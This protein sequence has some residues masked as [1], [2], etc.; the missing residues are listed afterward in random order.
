MAASA[1]KSNRA[2]RVVGQTEM[3]RQLAECLRGDHAAHAF[4]FSGPRGVGKAAV[5]LEFASLLLCDS[6]GMVPC[7]ECPQCTASTRL[8]HPDL[9]VIFPLPTKK[10]GSNEDSEKEFDKVISQ[11]LGVL[12]ADLYASAWPPKA[13]EIRIDSVRSVLHKASMKPYQA[14]SKVSVILHA[15]AMNVAAQNALLK[16][17]EEPPPEAF[18][19]L[20]AENEG[21]LLATIRSRCQRVRLL[22]LSRRDIAD[23]LIEDGIPAERAQTAAALAGGSFVRARELAG[24]DLEDLQKR[25][26]D[27]LRGAAMCDP[28]ELPGIIGALTEN[29][30]LPE[31]TP[32]EMLGLFLRDVAVSRSGSDQPAS[33]MFGGFEEAIRRLV[34]SYPQADLDAAVKAADRSADYLARGY[35]QEYVF[36]ALAIRLHDALGP[37]AAVKSKPTAT[38]HHA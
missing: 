20:T 32:L 16:V 4:L 23:H 37:R 26:V 10:A 31:G 18:F 7:R 24:S 15:D 11:Q 8:Q 19:L 21:E 5:A 14:R 28:L 35:S 25:V 13:K 12:A 9:Q 6:T 36:Y 2:W 3:R 17:L 38:A 29:S 22:P 30:K 33:L 34:A 27:F 1:V